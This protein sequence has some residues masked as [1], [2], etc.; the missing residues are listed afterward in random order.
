[1]M[2]DSA[3]TGAA[4]LDPGRF[5]G[6]P[7]VLELGRGVY[8]ADRAAALAGVPKSTLHYWARTGFYPP[9][10]SPGPRVRLWSW[11]DLLALRAIDWLR[12]EE[13]TSNVQQSSRGYAGIPR[14]ATRTIRL[15]LDEL[16]KRGIPRERL[17]DV[18]AA[19]QT[20]DLLVRVTGE[21]T[22]KAAPGRQL[23]IPDLLVFVRP[24]AGAPNLLQPRPLLRIIPGKLHGEPHVVGTRIG[25]ATLYALEEAGYTI[26]Q[27][28]RMYPDVSA[29]ALDQALNLEHSLRTSGQRAA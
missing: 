19:S 11:A 24:Y 3:G 25:S 17:I 28:R 7:P 29:E 18:L 5:P 9:S 4:I 26:E 12:R 23:P 1:M 27:V 10:I 20:G 22:V 6:E 15:A 14:V 2:A 21:Q 8:D 13:E 16:A